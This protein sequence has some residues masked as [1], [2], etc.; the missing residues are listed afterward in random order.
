MDESTQSSRMLHSTHI[1]HTQSCQSSIWL[2]HPTWEKLKGSL[3]SKIQRT[4]K[5]K[6]KNNAKLK[7]LYLWPLLVTNLYTVSVCH[8]NKLYPPPPLTHYFCVLVENYIVTH[9]ISVRYYLKSNPNNRKEWNLL[10]YT[11]YTHTHTLVSWFKPKHTM[12]G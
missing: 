9:I 5:K 12:I 8:L 11:A 2:R 1:P 10:V 4:Q 3:S 6:D 7:K